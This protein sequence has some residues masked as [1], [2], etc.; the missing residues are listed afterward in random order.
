MSSTKSGGNGRRIRGGGEAAAGKFVEAQEAA[1]PPGYV[2]QTL[3]GAGD[4]REKMRF[5]LCES[6]EAVRPQGLHQALGRG[7]K[8]Q[9]LEFLPAVRRPGK[10]VV[11]AKE[12]RLLLLAKFDVGI[13]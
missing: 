5:P 12:M 8:K 6:E 9:L 3:Q 11:T 4:V 13:V 10:I 2:Y 7:Q 1:R